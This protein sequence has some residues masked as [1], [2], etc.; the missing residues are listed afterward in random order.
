MVTKEE[1]EEA[2][3]E[4]EKG[5]FDESVWLCSDQLT[6]LLVVVIEDEGDAVNWRYENH[7]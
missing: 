4:E 6:V 5:E 2:D 1:E 3:G 7:D